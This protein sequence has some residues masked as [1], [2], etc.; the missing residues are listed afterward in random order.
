MEGVR[1]LLKLSVPDLVFDY[2]L[3]VP[4]GEQFLLKFS[5]KHEFSEFVVDYE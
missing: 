3:M 2:Q 5:F 4:F 1:N